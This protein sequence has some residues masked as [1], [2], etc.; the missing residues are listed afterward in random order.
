MPR[1]AA[2]CPGHRRARPGP[3][4]RE[5]VAVDP[6]PGLASIKVA[7]ADGG[8]AG[9]LITCAKSRL[10]LTLEIVKRP[11]DLHSFKALPP[12]MGGAAG[13]GVDHPQRTIRDY[14]R[15]PGHHEIHAHWATIFIMTRRLAR[16]SIA[17]Q[18]G[19]T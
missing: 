17:A 8:Y 13:F 7:W 18:P 9:K 2:G 5:A 16:Q 10:A 15:L 4:C 3:R 12:R 11:D 14:E 1:P 19:T 6:A